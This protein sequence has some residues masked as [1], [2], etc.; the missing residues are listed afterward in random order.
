MKKLDAQTLFLLSN[1]LNINIF[2]YITFSVLMADKLDIQSLIMSIR[3]FQNQV[4][5]LFVNF[6]SIFEQ[7]TRGI[8]GQK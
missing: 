2:L 8:F 5:I 1:L 6:N 4:I 3:S 7:L